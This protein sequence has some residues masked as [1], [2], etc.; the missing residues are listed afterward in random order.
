M[1]YRVS[2]GPHFMTRHADIVFSSREVLFTHNLL[3]LT[4]P[5]RSR[6]ISTSRGKH[7]QRQQTAGPFPDTSGIEKLPSQQN[8][9]K[10]RCFGLIPEH[11]CMGMLLGRQGFE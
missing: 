9:A 1:L 11:Y 4:F 10:V 3:P 5:L 7:V 8:F 6:T 2:K